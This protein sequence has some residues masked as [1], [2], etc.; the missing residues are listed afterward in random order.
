MNQNYC[1][2]RLPVYEVQSCLKFFVC[3]F[4]FIWKV[5]CR[6]QEQMF[7]LECQIQIQEIDPK[8]DRTH[9]IYFLALQAFDLT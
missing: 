4:L 1:N 2:L 8:K 5:S 9:E 3:F 6:N 7:L